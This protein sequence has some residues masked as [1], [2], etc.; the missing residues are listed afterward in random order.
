MS[1]CVFCQNEVEVVDR[2]GVRDDC[3]SCTR[4]LHCCLQCKFYDQ[5]A[6]HE[7]KERV[8]FRVEHKDRANYCD[9]FFFGGVA[10]VKVAD[11]EK[12][13]QDLDALFKKG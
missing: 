7:C 11:K 1:K 3:P 13:R 5:K 10:V 4:P 2:V 9:L 6:Y 8:D 12:I